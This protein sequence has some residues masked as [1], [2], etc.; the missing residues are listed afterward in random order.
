MALRF[1]GVDDCADC[2]EPEAMKTLTSL[3]ISLWF[4]GAREWNR[5]AI[6]VSKGDG[7]SLGFEDGRVV[8]RHVGLKTA[9]GRAADATRSAAAIPVEPGVWHRLRAS[10]A[11]GVVAIE[12]DGKEV[13]RTDGLADGPM[14]TNGP[15][16][17]GGTVDPRFFGGLLKD[18]RVDFVDGLR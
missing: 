10:W 18:V 11:K 15:L 7:L 9:D 8:F 3:A 4:Q 6:L 16:R 2:G 14:A 17:L 12:L 13:A 5:S 1:D